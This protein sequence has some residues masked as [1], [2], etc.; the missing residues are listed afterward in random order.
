ESDE[1]QMMY[2]C[3]TALVKDGTGFAHAISGDEWNQ[4]DQ[5]LTDDSVPRQDGVLGAYHYAR[6]S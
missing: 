3:R 1:A 2:T 5:F 4:I 6:R